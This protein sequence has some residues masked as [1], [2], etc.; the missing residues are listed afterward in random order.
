M[1]LEGQVALVAGGTRGGG[2][3]IAVQLGAAGATVYVSGRSSGS[4]RSDLGRPETIEE[5]A[6]LVT[7]AGGTGIPVRVDH[8]VPDEVRALAE[9]I[10]AE[11]DGRLDVL[12][13]SVW[14]GDALTDWEHPLWEQDLD[15]G[16]RLLRRA[17]ETHVIT[18]RFMLPLMVARRRGLAVEVT[19][20]NTARYR[21][22]FFYDLAK[23]S[24][25]RLA[26]AQAAELRPHG[27]AAVAITPGFLR[28]EHVLDHFGVTEEN[29]R[30]AVAKDPHF[31][32][33][34]TPAYLG[35]AVA[36]LAADPGVMSKTGRALATW[37]LYEE[38]GFTDVDGT[39]PDF[40]A[41]WADALVDEYGPLGDPL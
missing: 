14:G 4:E 9:R 1:T 19:D 40:A 12:V 25:I 20:G 22:S 6:E 16:L 34:E 27:V 21:G 38:Y 41:H 31:A 28:S 3:G 11:R 37:G 18:S 30:D 35:R 39:Q 32:Y 26:F 10:A 2:R 36:A 33:S 24:V 5:T 8:S 29:W 17:V 15:R 13:N 7:A 23:S